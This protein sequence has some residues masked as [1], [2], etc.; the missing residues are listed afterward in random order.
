M[1]K[2]SKMRLVA[3]AALLGGGLLSGGVLVP[4]FAMADPAP[5]LTLVEETE[6]DRGPTIDPEDLEELSR[7]AEEAVDKLLEMIGPL[8][9]SMSGLLADLPRYEPPEMLPNGDIIIRRRRDDP[10]DEPVEETETDI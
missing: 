3:A 7:E 4:T 10:F 5:A 1:T 9:E 8:M 6:S 2:I